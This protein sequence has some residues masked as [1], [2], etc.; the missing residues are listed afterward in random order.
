MATTPKE[1]I[2]DEQINPLMAQIIEI[3]NSHHIPV[4]AQFAL[5]TPEGDESQ[6]LCTT[7]LLEEA[8]EPTDE[9]LKAANIL[10]GKR[11]LTMLTVRDGDGKIKS[12]TAFV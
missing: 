4:V 7:Q 1:A 6:L 12:M 8:Y 10:M 11:P 5:G 9:Q 3:C 2:Y